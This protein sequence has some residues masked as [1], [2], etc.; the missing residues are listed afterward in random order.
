MG[1]DLA[2]LVR[3]LAEQ[4]NQEPG[5]GNLRLPTERELVDSLEISRGS[6]REQLSMLE[7]MGFLTR[8]QGRGSYLGVPD[9]SFLQLYF[10]LSSELGQLGG[11]QFRAAREMLEISMSEAAARQATADDVDTLRSLVDEM[12]QASAA[13]ADD[14]ALE[15]DLEFHRHLF[16]IVDNPIF[17]MLHDGLGHVLRDEVVERRHTAVRQETLKAGQTRAIDTVHYGIVDAVSE[18]DG[19]GARTAMRRHFEVWSSLTGR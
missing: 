19:E 15:A 12:V 2:Y 18:R 10:D 4:A 5:T 3:S 1:V 14:R 17:T 6:L 16:V 9:A 7:T 11:G 13:G 8:T